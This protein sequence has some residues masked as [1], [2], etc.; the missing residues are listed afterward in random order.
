M[1]TEYRKEYRRG[2]RVH[3]VVTSA[4]CCTFLFIDVIV[5]RFVLLFVLCFLFCF[6]MFKCIKKGYYILTFFIGVGNR[7]IMTK[8]L[9]LICLFFV[10]IC[11]SISFAGDNLSHDNPMLPFKQGLFCLGKF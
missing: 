6:Q 10:L 4:Y 8:K 11:L 5:G 2:H 1:L 3:R 9:S 7:D